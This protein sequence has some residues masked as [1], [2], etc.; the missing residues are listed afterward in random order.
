MPRKSKI[1]GSN[2]S[3][4]KEAVAKKALTYLNDDEMILGI[5]TGSTVN[6]F[7]EQLATIKHRIDA[8]IASSKETEA[9]LRALDIPVIDLNV[10]REVPFYIDGAD[11]VTEQRQMIKG[12]G[13]A[14]TREKILASVAN[15]FI[16]IIDE[17]KLVGHLGSFPV[18]VEVIPMARSYVARELVKLGGD[19]EYREGFITDN[20]NI[21]LDVYNFE[22]TKPIELEGLIKL[23]PGVVDNGLFAKRLA[24]TVLIATQN[25][26]KII[27]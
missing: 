27:R 10:A 16:C 11:E 23:I 26:I 21:I 4:L 19:P 24:D 1:Y 15:Q 2:M 20:G 13:G 14:L 7:I 18:A 25:D 12:G 22:I 8:C 9:R 3:T 5:G 6:C 17:S